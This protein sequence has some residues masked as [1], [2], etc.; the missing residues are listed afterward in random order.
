MEVG[1]AL[2]EGGG[3]PDVTN[4]SLGGVASR[5]SFAGVLQKWQDLSSVVILVGAS[6]VITKHGIATD[7]QVAA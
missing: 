7:V 1:T 4:N 3:N 6:E 5:A 2:A